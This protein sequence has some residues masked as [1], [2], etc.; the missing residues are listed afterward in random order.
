MLRKSVFKNKSVGLEAFCPTRALVFTVV[1]ASTV[2]SVIAGEVH[3]GSW[4][5]LILH[6]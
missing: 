6:F 1:T 2:N 5:C 3:S 4:F